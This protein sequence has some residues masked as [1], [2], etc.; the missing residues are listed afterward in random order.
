[1]GELPKDPA[2]FK[3]IPILLKESVWEAVVDAVT[4]VMRRRSHE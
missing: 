4:G 2:L 3:E 1:M